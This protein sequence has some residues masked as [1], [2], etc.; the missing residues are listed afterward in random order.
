MAAPTP[1]KYSPGVRGVKIFRDICVQM[2]LTSTCRRF[3][4]AFPNMY[5]VQNSSRIFDNY[6]GTIGK[7][8]LEVAD[9]DL[10]VI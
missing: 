2:M 8:E 4:I 1:L 3:Q 7:D 10:L 5:G 6:H 9:G